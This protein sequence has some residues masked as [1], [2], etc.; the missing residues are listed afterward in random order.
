MALA[1]LKEPIDP[2]AFL[3]W[4]RRQAERHELV[5]GVVRMMVGAAM[6]H[7]T[8]ADNIHVALATRLRG[9]PCR[10][11]RADTRVKSA[12]G[13][14]TYPDVLVSC[15]PRRPDELFVDDPVLVIEVLSP[16][17][18]DY[19]QIEKRWVYQSIASLRQLVFVSPGE[20]KVELVTREAD[21]SW[22]SVFVVGLD[23]SL[24]L[25]CLD[26]SLPM[27]EVYDGI[28]FAETRTAGG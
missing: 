26:L 1:A 4:E 23:A 17:T 2:D 19:D 5:G 24:A 22:R 18:E 3:D 6:G 8:V 28:S 27:A 9:A 7:N 16:S 10:A 11:W 20:A 15:T 21:Q 12:S 14:F 13:S 25:D